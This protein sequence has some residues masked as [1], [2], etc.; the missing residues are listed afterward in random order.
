MTRNNFFFIRNKHFKIE[1]CM[2]VN[3]I[4][5]TKVHARVLKGSI[6]KSKNCFAFVCCDGVKQKGSSQ[7]ACVCLCVYA[8]ERKI[9]Y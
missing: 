5:E 6:T 3:N 2:S 7:S 9:V 8:I 1:Q 4:V